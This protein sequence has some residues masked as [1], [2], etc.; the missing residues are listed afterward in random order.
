MILEWKAVCSPCSLE[1]LLFKWGVFV[2]RIACHVGVKTAVFALGTLHLMLTSKMCVFFLNIR[3][4]FISGMYSV[5]NELS[6][7]F[8]C[9]HHLPLAW[10]KG[11]HIQLGSIVFFV[12]VNEKIIRFQRA[13]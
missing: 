2:I 12:E 10:A 6:V 9:R 7:K 13:E 5:T 4:S 11:H 3:I 8:I 1:T